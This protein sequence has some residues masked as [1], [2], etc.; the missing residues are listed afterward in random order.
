LTV[1]TGFLLDESAET[2]SLPDPSRLP[3][4]LRETVEY[5]REEGIAFES[6]SAVETLVAL[7]SSEEKE[8]ESALRQ[9]SVAG[10][11]DALSPDFVRVL[12]PHQRRDIAHL[13]A[14]GNGA[15]FSVPGGGKTTVVYAAFDFLKTRGVVSKLLVIGPLSCFQPWEDEA[16]ACFGKPLRAAR[17]TGARSARLSLYLQASEYDLLLCSYQ[18]AANDFDDILDLCKAGSVMMVIDESHNIKRI[19]GGVRAEAVLKLAPYAARRVIL[20]GTPMPND[21]TDLWTQFTFLWPARRP[22]GDSASY[23]S[24]CEDREAWPAIR[25]EVRPLFTRTTKQELGLPPVRFEQVQ[26]TMSPL[27]RQIYH[28]LSV[29]FLRELDLQPEDQRALR[30]WR[31]ARMVRL[32]QAASNPALLAKYSEEFEVPPLEAEGIPIVRLIERYP[33]FEIPC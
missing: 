33:Q 11:F 7:Q 2:Y 14:V 13:L 12:K 23:R 6:D 1:A 21:F 29:K 28:A 18:T 22:L 32:I 27:Q 24:R 5:L 3:D 9:G 25:A 10:S 20:S 17:L 31:K 4:T 19:G 16:I 26:C 8:Y 30:E 15:N